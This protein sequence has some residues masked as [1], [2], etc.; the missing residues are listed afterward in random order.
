MTLTSLL[1]F[2]L[3]SLF[4]QG[5]Y[6]GYQRLPQDQPAEHEKIQDIP[7][8]QEPANS[9]KFA[10]QDFAIDILEEPSFGETLAVQVDNRFG[11]CQEQGN[12]S[13]RKHQDGK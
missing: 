7:G 3:G 2:F 1:G 13:C 4:C 12:G 9:G 10:S 5:L 11:G 6:E 8:T